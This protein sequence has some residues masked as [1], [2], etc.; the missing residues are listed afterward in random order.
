MIYEKDQ[1]T[2]YP[3]VE[4]DTYHFYDCL[5]YHHHQ[6][7]TFKIIRV[8]LHTYVLCCKEGFP[9]LS[10]LASASVF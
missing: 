7:S 3:H 10:L 1:S 2:V 9:T 6:S 5:N 8:D 4:N